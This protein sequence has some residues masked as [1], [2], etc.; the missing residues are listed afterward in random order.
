[1]MRGPHIQVQIG[2]LGEP[3]ARTLMR[4]CA[5]ICAWGLG[6]PFIYP[7]IPQTLVTKAL[8]GFAGFAENGPEE[9]ICPTVA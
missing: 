9:P 7:H 6:T 3:Y 4:V 1:M 8:W 2:F 5:H